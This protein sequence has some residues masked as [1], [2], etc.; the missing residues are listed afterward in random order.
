MAPGMNGGVA[1]P[2]T[3]PPVWHPSPRRFFQAI[4]YYLVTEQSTSLSPPPLYPQVTLS[5][6]STLAGGSDTLLSMNST[7]GELTII[8]SGGYRL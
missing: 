7:T 5:G 6:Q 8:V 1:G 4:P 3:V 2:H